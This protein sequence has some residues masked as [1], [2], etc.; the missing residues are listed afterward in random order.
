MPIIIGR[1][2]WK[3]YGLSDDTEPNDLNDS[4]NNDGYDLKVNPS[5]LNS[6]AA[7]VGQVFILN[8]FFLYIFKKNFL[9]FFYNV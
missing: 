4:E 3:H 5:T 8:Y 9:V 1:K 2:A 7:A 6:Y